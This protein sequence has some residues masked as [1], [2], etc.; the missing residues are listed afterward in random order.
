[1]NSEHSGF[2]IAEFQVLLVACRKFWTS[3][4]LLVDQLMILRL[5]HFV[6]VHLKQSFFLGVAKF[7]H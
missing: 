1:M 5:L 7:H 6:R 4:K 3:L 2:Y